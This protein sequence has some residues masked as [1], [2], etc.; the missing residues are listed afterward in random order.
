MSI[1]PYYEHAGVTIYHGD[2]R[3]VL[4]GLLD[5]GVVLADPPY[6]V[7]LRRGDGRNNDRVHV[8]GAARGD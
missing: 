5:V 2:C 1:R 3:E 6:G 7:A 4:P 8:S